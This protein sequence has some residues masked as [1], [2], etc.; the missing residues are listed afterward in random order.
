MTRPDIWHEMDVMNW[1]ERWVST[2]L[3]LLILLVAWLWQ[4][5]DGDSR[6]RDL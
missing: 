4:L 1:I 2:A 5:V 6:E 3:L